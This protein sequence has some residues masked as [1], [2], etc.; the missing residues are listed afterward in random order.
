M[1]RTK[2]TE[3]REKSAEELTRLAAEKSENLFNLKVRCIQPLGFSPDS[4][5][6]RWRFL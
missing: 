2:P 6:V 5:G 3:L 1:K 4:V